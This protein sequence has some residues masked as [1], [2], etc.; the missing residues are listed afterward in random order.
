LPTKC[1]FFALCG[2]GVGWVGVEW[3]GN[4][5]MFLKLLSKTTLL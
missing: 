3:D 2:G 4:G 5:M 1:V